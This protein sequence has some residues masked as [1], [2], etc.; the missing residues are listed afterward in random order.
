LESLLHPQ[1][2]LDEHLNMW[3]ASGRT[4]AFAIDE[5]SLNLKDQRA[6]NLEAA[7][8]LGFTDTPARRG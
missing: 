5:R 4:A 8:N 7:V 2:A 6:E 1:K 3:A